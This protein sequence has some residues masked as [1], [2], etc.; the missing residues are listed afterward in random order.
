[1][2]IKKIICI[3]AETENNKSK[4]VTRGRVA[5]ENEAMKSVTGCDGKVMEKT[6]SKEIRK[7]NKPE[8]E[9]KKDKQKLK[10]NAIE[11]VQ[12]KSI[13]DVAE[14]G[15]A[16]SKKKLNENIEQQP[17]KENEKSN[18]YIDLKEKREKKLKENL[19][20]NAKL[21]PIEIQNQKPENKT[22]NKKDK[23]KLKG[24]AKRK[25][26]ENVEQQKSKESEVKF[27][28]GCKGE[29]RRETERKFESE[30]KAKID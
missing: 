21:K 29:K 10:G 13:T 26:N 17:S 25:L 22:N 30:R 4:M 9:T 5:K 3:K 15:Q 7:L 12:P 1:M 23:Q 2:I 6:K 18:L 28:H 11:K 19:N 8:N 20:S 27:M 16:Q 14:R 24:N